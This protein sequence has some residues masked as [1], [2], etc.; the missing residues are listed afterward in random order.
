LIDDVT[1]ENFPFSFEK[2]L[3]EYPS[4]SNLS[5][6]SE[7]NQN[8]L[9]LTPKQGSGLN[10]RN[11]RLWI[12]KDNLVERILIEQDNTFD[13]YITDYRI[14]QNIPESRFNFDVPEGTSVID[15]R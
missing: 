10:F 4:K 7:G 1:E 13:I 6:V 9:I 2:I 14:N 5:S 3:N 15:L 11:A 8:I 12:N